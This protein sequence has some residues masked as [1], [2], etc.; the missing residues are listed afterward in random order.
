MRHVM[1]QLQEINTGY[2]RHF[3]DVRCFESRAHLLSMYNHDDW[4]IACSQIRNQTGGT[5]KLEVQDVAVRAYLVRACLACHRIATWILARSS[6]NQSDTTSTPRLKEKGRA[7]HR[8]QKGVRSRPNPYCAL[9][10]IPN[11]YPYTKGC[12]TTFSSLQ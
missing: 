1:E 11:T 5:Q 6:G 10:S 9:T 2:K 4:L 7:S 8:V 3:G 12:A